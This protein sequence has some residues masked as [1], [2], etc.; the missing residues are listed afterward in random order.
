[1]SLSDSLLGDSSIIYVI[2]DLDADNLD[3]EFK[4]SY[5]FELSDSEPLNYNFL[6]ESLKFLYNKYKEITNIC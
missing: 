4:N 2:K 3:L 6:L 5:S 1:M